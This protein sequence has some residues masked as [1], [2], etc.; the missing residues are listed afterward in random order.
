MG[1]YFLLQGISLTQGSNQQLLKLGSH[2]IYPLN[3][4]NDTPSKVDMKSQWDEHAP[5][6]RPP[7]P[8]A[9]PPRLGRD[10]RLWWYRVYPLLHQHDIEPIRFIH[11]R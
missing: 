10:V 3:G 8:H 9:P 7:R 4:I 5:T 11:P 1:C 2:K 6:P